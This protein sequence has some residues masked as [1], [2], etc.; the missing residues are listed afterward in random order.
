VFELRTVAAMTLRTA[1]WAGIAALAWR[2]LM[3][4]R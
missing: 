2:S 1:I 4:T 3:P